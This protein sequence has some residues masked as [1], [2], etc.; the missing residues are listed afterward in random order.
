MKYSADSIQPEALCH[1]PATLI[2]TDRPLHGITEAGTYLFYIYHKYYITQLKM[3]D[4]QWRIILYILTYMN[5]KFRELNSCGITC[6]KT[7]DTENI[8]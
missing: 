7:Y 8:F 4:D 1:P 5:S 6:I 2:C 3:N